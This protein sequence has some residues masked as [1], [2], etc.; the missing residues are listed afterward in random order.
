[1]L[2]GPIDERKKADEVRSRIKEK[3]KLEGFVKKAP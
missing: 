1:V 3:T 2:V